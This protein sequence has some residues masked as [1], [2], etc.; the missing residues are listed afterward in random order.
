MFI[1]FREN[2]FL[3]CQYTFLLQNL[4]NHLKMYDLSFC[5]YFI[6]LFFHF[7]LCIV[8]LYFFT[9]VLYVYI[10]LFYIFCIY[11]FLHN[12]LLLLT[13]GG[14][15]L[16]CKGL[17][18]SDWWQMCEMCISCGICSVFVWSMYISMCANKTFYCHQ[19]MWF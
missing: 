19:V 13:S 5:V 14:F 11:I 7:T 3:D 9:F 16:K 8:S 6:F 10:F 12:C 18:E 17:M 1:Q 4:R 15:A 2:L